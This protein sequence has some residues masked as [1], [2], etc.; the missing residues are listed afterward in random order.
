MKRLPRS[1]RQGASGNIFCYLAMKMMKDQAVQ[2]S[3][4]G[5]VPARAGS[6]GITRKNIRMMAGKPLLAYTATAALNACHLS[7]VLL[8][9]DDPEIAAI[10]SAA[11]LEVPFLRPGELALDSTPMVQVVL[12][13]IQWLHARGQDYDAVCVLQPTSPLRSSG[14]IDRCISLL[15]E[16]DVD[17]VISVRPVPAEYNPHWVYFE[18]PAGLLEP[19][20]PGVEIPCR[21]QL[22]R[23]YHPDGSVFVA[24]TQIV[25]GER[26]LKGKRTLGAVSPEQEAVDL[27]TEEQWQALEQRLKY[28][29]EPA[30]LRSAL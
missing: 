8:S 2:R 20:I 6:K 21:Q 17:S 18:T 7:R 10:G 22:P 1:F 28:N 26:S 25:I 29:H 5:I 30:G 3:V 24:R 11:G 4:L 13:A 15:W 23:A 19:S 12:H 14:T 27:D 9:S 16:R